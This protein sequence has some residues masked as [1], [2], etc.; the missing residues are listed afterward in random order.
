MALI[1]F[2]SYRDGGLCRIMSAME[3]VSGKLPTN[4]KTKTINLGYGSPPRGTDSSSHQMVM[5]QENV[6]SMLKRS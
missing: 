6:G 3:Q 4:Y 1:S 5:L 2:Q